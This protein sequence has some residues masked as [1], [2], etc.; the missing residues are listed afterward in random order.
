MGGGSD[1]V[2]S[3]A[4]SV[5]LE[6]DLDALRSAVTWSHKTR[7]VIRQNLAWALLYNL[8]ILPLAGMGFF[9]PYAAAIGMSLSSLLVVGN[10]LRLGEVRVSE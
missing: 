3:R 2:R 1:L 5:L 6:D 9:A 10:A 8:T 7:R 4:D